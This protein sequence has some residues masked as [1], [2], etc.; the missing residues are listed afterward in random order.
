MLVLSGNT[1][2][3]FRDIVCPGMTLTSIDSQCDGIRQEGSDVILKV[4]SGKPFLLPMLAAIDF[5]VIPES[6]VDRNS[7]TLDII[8]YS[9]TSGAYYVSHDDDAGKIELQMNPNS[10]H[11]ASDIP[12][13]VALVPVSAEIPDGT[14]KAFQEGRADHLMSY[15]A[16]LPESVINYGANAKDTQLHVTQKIQTI[17]IFFSDR[18]RRELSLPYR[19]YIGTE[20]KNI[21]EKNYAGKPGFAM[22]DDFFPA[23]GDGGLTNSMQAELKNLLHSQNHNDGG[24]FILGTLKDVKFYPWFKDVQ[25]HFPQAEFRKQENVPAFVKFANPSDEPHAVI[26][27]TDTSFS[28]DIGLISYSMNAG[29]LGLKHDARQ[30]W[31]ADY[32]NQTSKSERLEKLKNLHFEALS[33]GELYPL[34][35]SPYAALI[36][37]PWK[38]E[39]SDLYANNQLWLIKI[40]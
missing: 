37:N 19:N 15:S 10:F 9:E 34:I 7:K 5:A 12:E 20:M 2:G 27:G 28:E 23:S 14:L 6:S 22:A 39:L 35:V 40:R 26:C 32:M 29:F 1:H 4:R 30:R 38:M 11:A 24:K 33:K 13:H 25:D 21:F 18:G 3:N 17:L 8:D 16:S 36:R 31:L